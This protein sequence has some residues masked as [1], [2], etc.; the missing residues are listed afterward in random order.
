[1]SVPVQGERQRRRAHPETLATLLP[2]LRPL[3]YAGD[4]VPQVDFRPD[5]MA[6]QQM[7]HELR[8]VLER[9]VTDV[10]GGRL[11]DLGGAQCGGVGRGG[12][13]GQVD[14]LGSGGFRCRARL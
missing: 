2:R 8:G 4:P 10:A 13:V 7:E 9:H 12:D 14:R 6:N 5:T 1:M 11:L 3:L